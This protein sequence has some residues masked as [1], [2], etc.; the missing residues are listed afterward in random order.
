M[1]ALT[2]GCEK[3]L[4][5]SDVDQNR[6]FGTDSA[7]TEKLSTI[8]VELKIAVQPYPFYTSIYVSYKQGYRYVNLKRIAA[9]IQ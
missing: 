9:S 8:G 1:I 2:G 3:I 4:T 6:T 7:T 5:A